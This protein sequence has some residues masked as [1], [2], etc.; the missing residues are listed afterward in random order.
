MN[1][2]NADEFKFS[3]LNYSR[4]INDHLTASLNKT[5]LEFGLTGMQVILLLKLFKD[6]TTTIGNL[7]EH[8]RVAGANI[9]SMCKELEQKGFLTRNRDKRDERIV[10]ISLTD[11][12]L[13]VM[14]EIDQIFEE[15]IQSILAGEKQETLDAIIKGLKL[16]DILFEK[17]EIGNK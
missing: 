16:L 6:G 3:I 14:S 15:K 12:G 5:G 10:N 17:I 8:T 11:K 4:K 2:L 13:S 1:G 7:A 9:S